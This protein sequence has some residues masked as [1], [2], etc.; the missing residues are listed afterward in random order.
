M[1]FVSKTTGIPLAR[2]A[3]KA[4]LGE[5]LPNLESPLP[6]KDYS[7]KVPTFSWLKLPGLDTT[8]GT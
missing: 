4:M 3:V 7:V 2:L 6:V 5:K 8:L 1:P